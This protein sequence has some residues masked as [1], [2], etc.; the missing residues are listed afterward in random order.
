MFGTLTV[1]PMAPSLSNAIAE[2][3]R[4][5]LAGRQVDG[6]EFAAHVGIPKTTG[7]RKIQG[8]SKMTI[9]DVEAFALGLGWTLPELVARGSAIRDAGG[10]AEEEDPSAAEILESM[11]PRERR[12]AQ[13]IREEHAA[14]HPSAKKGR[15]R[16]T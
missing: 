16:S 7:W 5:E 4:R 12:E 15:R 3:I 14:A 2:V 8:K 1:C 6:A 11:T 13:R 9:D 10:V